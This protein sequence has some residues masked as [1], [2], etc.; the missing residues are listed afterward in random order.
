MA[1][2]SR[3]MA[4]NADVRYR[5]Y[6]FYA[7]DNVAELTHQSGADVDVR[8]AFINNGVL[9]NSADT[10]YRAINDRYPVFGFAKNLGRVGPTVVSTM[11]TINLAQELSIQFTDSTGTH[12]ITSLWTIDFANELDAVCQIPSCSYSAN[13]S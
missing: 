10:D 4:Q 13:S 11:F 9:G 7:T 12:G 8:S 5:G 1:T 6:W 2:N 3:E